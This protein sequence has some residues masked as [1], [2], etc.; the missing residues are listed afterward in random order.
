MLDVENLLSELPKQQQQRDKS[1]WRTIQWDTISSPTTPSFPPESFTLAKRQ[2][3][4]PTPCGNLPSP[5]E[6]V[7]IRNRLVYIKRDDLLRLKGSNVSGN[8]ARKMY[9]LNEISAEDFPECV[10]SYGGPQ[11][12]AMVAL[13]AI[14]HSKNAEL[15]T[16]PSFDIVEAPMVDEIGQLDGSEDDVKSDRRGMAVADADFARGEST[17]RPASNVR[18]RRFVYYTK[19]LPRFLRNQPNGNLFRAQTLGMEIVELS[20]DE[21]SRLFGTESGGRP[22]AHP[23]LEPPVPGDS[24]WVST[25]V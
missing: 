17:S 21:Y 19:T 22:E 20:H 24:L 11:S 3:L 15:G 7:L 1:D 6:Q 23:D 14:V 13:A 18:R 8:K 25:V 12:N 4:R 16:I 10:V 2:D 5:V 9:A